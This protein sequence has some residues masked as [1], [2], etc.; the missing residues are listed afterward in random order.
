MLA[1][2]ALCLS[3]DAIDWLAT[4]S[5]IVE[6]GE[7][8]D[9][10]T[11]VY[12]GSSELAGEFSRDIFLLSET[13]ELT[14]DFAKNIWAM[15]INMRFDGEC[16]EMLRLAGRT[17]RVAGNAK[18]GAMLAGETVKVAGSA[19]IG[20]KLFILGGDVI[21]DGVCEGDVKIIGNRV[22]LGGNFA[23]NVDISGNDIV[24]KSS[25]VIEGDLSYQ[26]QRELM[27]PRGASLAGELIRIAPEPV[28][29]DTFQLFLATVFR[30]FFW[31]IAALIVGIPFIYL[32][33]PLAAN[34][35][36]GLRLA[37]WRCMLLGFAVAILTPL[38]ALA[39]MGV[40]IGIPLGM[41]LLGSYGVLLFIA[42]FPIAMFFGSLIFRFKRPQHRSAMILPLAAGLGVFYVLTAIPVVGGTLYFIFTVYGVG[43]LLVSAIGWKRRIIELQSALAAKSNAPQIEK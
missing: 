31:Y 11:W 38:F 16:A 27:L 9:S 13:G 7:R 29:R 6:E 34:A 8:I 43:A 20:D 5:Y 17:L 2:I 40:I 23:G 18:G 12:T 1:V 19:V 24:V 37:P 10:E 39:L 14:G 36:L 30:Q 4:E 33:E 25:T 26:S 15:G 32:F 42:R 22:T 35:M 28:E 21:V 3:A 41:L